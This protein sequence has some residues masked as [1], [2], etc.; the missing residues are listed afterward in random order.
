M[1]YELGYRYKNN[2]KAFG[3]ETIF[4]L[5]D[6]DNLIVVDNLGA[7][8][9]GLGVTE[10]AG[11]VRSWGFE[12]QTQYDPGVNLQ[13]S[14]KNPWYANFTYTHAKFRETTPST[15]TESIFAAAVAGN[16]V[17]YIPEWQFNVGTGL[18]IGKFSAFADARYVD[19]TFAT[20]NNSESQLNPLTGRLDSRFGTTDSFLILDLSANYQ[21]NKNLK[22]FTNFYNVANSQYMVTRAPEGPRPGAPFQAFA[23]IEVA[24]F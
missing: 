1:G 19:K 4:F 15:N 24:F 23:G 2:P 12:F 16:R 3:A 17:P 6:L 22:F 8:G 9:G 7:S 14:F 13:W 20:G 10:N 21:Y 18:I 11:K 5:T